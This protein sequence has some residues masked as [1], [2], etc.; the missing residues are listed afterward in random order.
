MTS[1]SGLPV[2][3]SVCA[4]HLG[5][6]LDQ[7]AVQVALV[8]FGEDVGDLGRGLAEPV[9]QQ[10]VG[11][12]DELHI[13]VLDAVVHH[14]HEVPGAVG[15]DVGAARHAVDVRGDLLEQRA[16]R[17]VG[18]GRAAGH[19]R[20]ALQRALLAAGDAGADE[21]QPALAD[22]LLAADGVGVERVAAVDDD[23]AFF[24][25]VG[26]LVDHGVGR[27]AGLDHDDH[28]A[29]LLQCGKEFGDRLAAD[30]V[31][32]RAVLLQQ[33]I[34]LGDRAVVQRHGVAVVGEVA[35]EVRAHHGQAG[36]ADLSGAVGVRSFRRAH[37]GGLSLFVVQNGFDY[38]GR[39]PRR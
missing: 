23:V 20:R 7:E 34:G 5:G 38:D 35:G 29:R 39:S 12:A 8:P 33:R 19:D 16:E 37:S 21:V 15:A 30:E 32:L 13:G 11:L 31:A 1:T 28:P 22:R 14:L 25:R 36:D 24:H 4:Q 26:E 10:L 27:I 3:A 6:D 2:L 9:A 18:L 17:L